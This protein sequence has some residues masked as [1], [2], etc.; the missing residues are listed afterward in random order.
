MRPLQ[1]GDA[2]PGGPAPPVRPRRACTWSASAWTTPAR[3][4]WYRAVARSLGVTYTLSASPDENNVA[5]QAYGVSGI[6]AQFLI[7]KKGVLR[8]NQDGYSESEKQKL[9]VLIQKLLAEPA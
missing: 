6:P 3:S 4:P 8:W 5:Q 2:D 1:D 9:T 7:D